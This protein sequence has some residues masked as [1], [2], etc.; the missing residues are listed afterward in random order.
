MKYWSQQTVGRSGG[1]MLSQTPP[2]VF[3]SYYI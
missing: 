3:K 1:E 2:T